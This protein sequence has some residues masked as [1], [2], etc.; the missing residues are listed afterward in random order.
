MDEHT[1][2]C[3][4]EMGRKKEQVKHIVPPIPKEKTRNFPSGVANS[5]TERKFLWLGGTTAD[6]MTPEIN[7]S[8]YTRTVS[9]SNTK[10]YRIVPCSRRLK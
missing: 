2:K 9:K 5:V 6:S 1:T 7:L 4:T 3:D 10:G 8:Q